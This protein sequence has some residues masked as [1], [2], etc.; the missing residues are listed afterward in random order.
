MVGVAKKKSESGSEIGKAR[1]IDIGEFVKIAVFGVVIEDAR[2]LVGGMRGF[3]TARI[4]EELFG[5][6]VVSDD[7][8]NA[9]GFVNSVSETSE[10]E[11][12]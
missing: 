7:D 10:G 8:K 3:G 5:I 12:D 4:V 6:A 11:I 9:M 2:D 1:V